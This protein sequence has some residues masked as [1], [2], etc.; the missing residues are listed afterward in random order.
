MPAKCPQGRVA[1]RERAGGQILGLVYALGFLLAVV[2]YIGVVTL[3][4]VRRGVSGA[5]LALTGT[6]I[7][8][9][10]LTF[11]VISAAEYKAPTAGL[12]ATTAA[13]TC[14][15]PRDQSSFTVLPPSPASHRF[16]NRHY[17]WPCDALPVSRALSAFPDM[18]YPA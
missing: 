12:T 10:W 5:F 3:A 11:F 15:R 18:W 16:W 17:R 6:A 7:F 1:W 13:P 9:L 4:M 8:G 2:L 14:K